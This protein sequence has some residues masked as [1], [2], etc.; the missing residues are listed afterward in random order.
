MEGQT[1]QISIP[2]LD[3]LGPTVEAA[4]NFQTL[5]ASGIIFLAFAIVSSIL[6]YK[7]KNDKKIENL[8]TY[9][10]G[11]NATSKETM[12]MLK[13]LLQTQN[14]VVIERVKQMEGNLTK[15]EASTRNIEL[16]LVKHGIDLEKS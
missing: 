4:K 5:D 8:S 7:V 3:A 12:D 1:S 14:D 16:T 6:F 10:N 13:G 11:I 9:I 15:I 2:V